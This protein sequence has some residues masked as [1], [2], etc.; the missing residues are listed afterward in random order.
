M[1]CSELVAIVWMLTLSA[2]KD[3][4]LI[5]A[6]FPIKH[7]SGCKPFNLNDLVTRFSSYWMYVADYQN[8]VF[9]DAF[10]PI[11]FDA[12]SSPCARPQPGGK[13]KRRKSTRR[14]RRR[15]L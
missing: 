13:Q 11:V 7:V 4:N 10:T 1:F 3:P 2:N 15:K 5:R 12:K 14:R 6:A 9:P 8:I